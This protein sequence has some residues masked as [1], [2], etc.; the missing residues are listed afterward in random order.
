MIEDTR[1]QV[2]PGSSLTL[3]K[4]RSGLI[5]RGLRD[6]EVLAGSDPLWSETRRPA[7][8]G[9]AS[10]QYELGNLYAERYKSAPWGFVR[11]DYEEAVEW[12]RKAAVQG[13][14]K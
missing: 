12:Y 5:A 8:A 2:T 13:L 9:D 7:E 14:A 11:A 6:A 3:S 10:A 1:L 4:A